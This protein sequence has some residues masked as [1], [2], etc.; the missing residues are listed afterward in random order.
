METLPTLSCAQ[1][2]VEF[3]LNSRG[4]HKKFCSAS[5]RSLAY[6][7]S[8]AEYKQ[9]VLEKSSSRQKRLRQENDEKLNSYK[10]EKGCA[11]CGF[12]SNPRALQ[13][14]HI[15]PLEKSFQISSHISSK[16]WTEILSE[17][18]KCEI[19]CANCHAIHSYDNKH[20]QIRRPT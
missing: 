18:G 4:R 2:G 14:N 17:L 16:S 3:T 1:C 9:K 19:L 15:N 8:N 5:C 13:C 7:H 6:Y 10:I 12:N 11:H 20:S